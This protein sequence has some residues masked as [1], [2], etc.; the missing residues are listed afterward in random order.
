MY[1]RADRVSAES[2]AVH[3][4]RLLA[5]RALRSRMSEAAR[6][7]VDPSTA[8]AIIGVIEELLRQPGA[9]PAHTVLDRPAGEACFSA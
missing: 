7:T 1:I 3:V 5:D 8:N 4:A 2:V 6:A 9:G